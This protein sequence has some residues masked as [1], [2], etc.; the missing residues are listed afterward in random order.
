[1]FPVFDLPVN[2]SPCITLHY[3]LLIFNKKAAKLLSLAAF[4]QGH[5]GAGGI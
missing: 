1:M 5:G 2:S 3:K 4:K